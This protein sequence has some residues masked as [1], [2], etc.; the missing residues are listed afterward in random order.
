MPCNA[1]MP[2]WFTKERTANGKRAVSFNFRE[3]Y[4][5]LPIEI[6]CG[7]C[8]GCKLDKSKEWALRCQHEALENDENTFVTLTYNEKNLPFTTSGRHPALPTLYPIHF[9]NFVKRLRRT[10]RKIR[11]F[12]CGEYGE[13]LRPHHHA[14]LFNCYFKDQKLLKEQPTGNLYTS[15]ELEKLWPHGY[16]SL[17]Q[18]TYESAGY[19]A[20]Y[21]LKKLDK[22][23]QKKDT[24]Y[25]TYLTM[26]RNPG[27]GSKHFD[28]YYEQIYNFDEVI[29]R[30]GNKV[31]PPRY[32]DN[33]YEKI[34]PK[35]LKEI[36]S[37]R[38]KEVNQD[39][40]RGTR[41]Y[42][43]EYLLKRKIQDQLQRKI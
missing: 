35:H 43:K 1:P 14:L 27:I 20:R 9:T 37:N 25:P 30:A 6:R 40:K 41:Y 33:K 3:S 39:E 17:G 42:V 5:D 18:V 31:K 38:I 13:L 32:Y 34:N 10:G 23:E 26:S 36:K 19:V 12:Q 21:T 11:Y 15:Q 24:R 7:K 8:L 2:G 22:Q 4:C 28:K 29:T 16:S